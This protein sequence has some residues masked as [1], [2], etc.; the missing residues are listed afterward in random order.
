MNNN[1]RIGMKD[2]DHLEKITVGSYLFRQ[3][4][5]DNFYKRLHKDLQEVNP[6]TG[7]KKTDIGLL[8]IVRT[9]FLKGAYMG[10]NLALKAKEEGMPTTIK[11]MADLLEKGKTL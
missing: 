5:G 3:F 2:A 8:Y 10:M 4:Q 6:A 7:R 1:D 9:V 11:G